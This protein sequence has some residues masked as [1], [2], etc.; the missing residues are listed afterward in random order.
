MDEYI[1][2]IAV[3]RINIKPSA[4]LKHR[5]QHDMVIA[6]VFLVAIAASKSEHIESHNL[7]AI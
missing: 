4:F 1:L 7:Y 6:L 5:Q 3:K 2:Y